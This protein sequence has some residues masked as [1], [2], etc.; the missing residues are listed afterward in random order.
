MKFKTIYGGCTKHSV[1]ASNPMVEQYMAV[2]PYAVD[3]KTG[4]CLNSSPIVKLVKCDSINIQERIQSFA[5]ECDLYTILERYAV[6]GDSSLLNRNVMSFA[7][8]VGIP[9]N[10]NDFNEFIQAHI[11]GLSK[12][13]PEIAQ[14][15]LKNDIDYNSIK[16]MIDESVASALLNQVKNNIEVGTTNE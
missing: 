1:D 5:R 10:K 7:D 4:E 14:Q 13:N 9:D 16:K 11:I 8:I 6:S 3:A 15:L 12:T 2:E